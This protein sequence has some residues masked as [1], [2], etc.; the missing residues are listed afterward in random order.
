M[1]NPVLTK[2]NKTPNIVSKL[3]ANPNFSMYGILY[4]PKNKVTITAE[5]IN[6]F[7]YSANK[8]KPKPIELYSVWYPPINSVSHSGKSK[9]V[10]FVSANAQIRNI[11]KLNG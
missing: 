11:I 9:G 3:C 4:P 10:L 1:K 8:Y 7:T 5:E 2:K 6:I